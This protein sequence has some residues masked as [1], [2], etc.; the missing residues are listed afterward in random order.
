VGRDSIVQKGDSFRDRV[1]KRHKHE[2]GTGDPEYRPPPAA[3][4][5]WRAVNEESEPSY[6][7]DGDRTTDDDAFTLFHG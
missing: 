1:G 3:W 7:K 4:K 5:P 2:Y 6:Q